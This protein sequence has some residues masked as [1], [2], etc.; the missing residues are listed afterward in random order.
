[1]SWRSRRRGRASSRRSR[2]TAGRRAGPAGRLGAAGLRRRRRRRRERRLRGRRLGVGVGVGVGVAVWVGDGEGEGLPEASLA[3]GTSLSAGAA[4]VSAVY[5]VVGRRPLAAATLRPDDSRCRR[6]RGRRARGAA[7]TNSW[8]S[9]CRRPA[10]ERDGRRAVRGAQREVGLHGLRDR[11]RR[12]LRCQVVDARRLVAAE[13]H[14]AGHRDCGD[15]DHED[16]DDQPALAL[17]HARSPP[18]APR[19][20]AGVHLGP[21]LEAPAGLVAARLPAL[22][23]KRH[24]ALSAAAGEPLERLQCT[25]CSRPRS[26]RRRPRSARRTAGRR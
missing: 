3:R 24:A 11:P 25:R 1:M 2:R 9:R 21:S 22:L 5:V 17:L 6:S 12:R 13:P 26:G 4:T 23:R 7:R 20:P 19:V 18:L 8:T 16:P 15:D 10:A 14:D